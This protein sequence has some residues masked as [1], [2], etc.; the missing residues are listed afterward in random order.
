[1]IPGLLVSSIPQCKLNRRQGACLESFQAIGCFESMF[2]ETHQVSKTIC[3][4]RSLKS[5]KK[6]HSSLEEI[7]TSSIE[8]FKDCESD[9]AV[10]IRKLGNTTQLTAECKVIVQQ[11]ACS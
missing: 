10:G 3:K 5:Q 7:I 1:M 9:M 11:I 2:I 8:V 6:T 4:V